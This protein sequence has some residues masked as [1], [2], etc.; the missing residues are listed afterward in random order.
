MLWWKWRFDMLK[1]LNRLVA[2]NGTEKCLA[3]DCSTNR[4]LIELVSAWEW[5]WAECSFQREVLP[6][7]VIL[8]YEFSKRILERL[9]WS[10]KRCCPTSKA[11]VFTFD[12]L[13][14]IKDDGLN[15]NA[16]CKETDDER[17]INEK[18]SLWWKGGWESRKREGKE[19]TRFVKSALVRKILNDKIVVPEW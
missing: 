2:T 16:G 12:D 3:V 1:A 10:T 15:E 13:L 4:W 5:C 7:G 9:D 18:L 8:F 11:D 6:W 19:W 17:K 14:F